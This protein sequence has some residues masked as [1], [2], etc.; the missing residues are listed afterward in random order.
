MGALA[1]GFR[2]ATR[3]VRHVGHD[4]RKTRPPRRLAG[5]IAVA[6]G[7]VLLL[8]TAVSLAIQA[9]ETRNNRE[10]T[11]QAIADLNRAEPGWHFRD[12][13]PAGRTSPTRRIRYSSCRRPP[14]CY[15]EKWPLEP[16]A[17][18]PK[19]VKPER[20]TSKTLVR[21]DDP[22]RA[23]ISTNPSFTDRLKAELKHFG[24]RVGTGPKGRK[25]S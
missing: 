22:S 24:A 15:L 4:R 6:V 25:L 13:G 9:R 19:N 21:A 10:K 23:G 14:T 11:R 16:A 8:S 12:L 5:S 1:E 18:K 20:P 7:T 2:R 3:G 17:P